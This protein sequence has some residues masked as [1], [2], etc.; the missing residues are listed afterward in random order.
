MSSETSSD[1]KL[2]NINYLDKNGN[3][4]LSEK[5]ELKKQSS[6]TDYYFNMIV[7]TD[8]VI[9]SKNNSE[10][11]SDINISS[12]SKNKISLSST[13]KA[14]S[15]ASS[16]SS[17]RSSSKPRYDNIN[18]DIPVPAQLPFS[19]QQVTNNYQ[20][21][22]SFQPVQ[23]VQPVPTQPVQA[24]KI[25]LFKST[26]PILAQAATGVMSSQEIKMKKIELLRKLCEIKAKGYQLTKDYDFNSSIEEMEYEYSLLKSFADKRNGV[27]LYKSCLLNGISVLEFLNDKYDPFD[28]KLNGW[29]EHMSVEADSYDDIFE[30]LYEKYKSTSSGLPVEAKLLILIVASG[31]SFHFSK[32]QLASIPTSMIGKMMSNTKQPSQFMTPQEVNLENQKKMMK[33]KE[34]EIKKKQQQQLKNQINSETMNQT[35]TKSNTPPSN[36]LTDSTPFK[37]TTR[38]MPEIRAPENVKEILDRIKA[39]QQNQINT[40]ETQDESTTNNDRI[41]SDSTISETKKKG[42][43]TKKPLLTIAT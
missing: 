38:D 25:D 30:E 21:T 32:T 40:T 37:S 11:D 29:S 17:T 13:S 43:K 12:S 20:N 16:K 1:N 9:N 4:I 41:I 24:P 2:S 6:E 3:K 33:E 26:I 18:M 42:K 14:S 19:T 35:F 31:A 15:K 34:Q 36:P 8:K 5:P 10:S 7:N 27:K 39:I 23:P 22:Q 28:F